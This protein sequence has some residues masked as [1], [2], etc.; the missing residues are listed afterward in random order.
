MHKLGSHVFSGPELSNYAQAL[1][2]G[3]Q[4]L[5]LCNPK[6]YSSGFLLDLHG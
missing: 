1:E 2:S 3:R 5:G 4:L 6:P